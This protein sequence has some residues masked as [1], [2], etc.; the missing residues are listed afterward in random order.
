MKKYPPNAYFDS[1]LLLKNIAYLSTMN[2]IAPKVIEFLDHDN[3]PIEFETSKEKTCTCGQGIERWFYV[4]IKTA[5]HYWFAQHHRSTQ[6]EAELKSELEQAKAEIR[7]LKQKRFGKS[8]ESKK[9]NEKG[10]EAEN[11][12]RNRGQQPGSLG[13][14]RKKQ[15]LEEIE[16]I[17]EFPKDTMYCPCCRIPYEALS[18]TEDSEI[19]EIAVKGYKRKIRRR[20]Y[21]SRCFCKGTPKLLL[22]PSVPRLIPKGKIGTTIWASILMDKYGGY[23]PTHR[24]I[25]KLETYGIELAFGTV[26]DGLKKLT[27]LF[28]P[29]VKAILEKNQKEKH[30]HADETRWEVF[31][32]VEGKVSSRWY[33]W[34]FKS[35]SSVYY[36]LAPSRG[37]R[38]PKD[39][40]VGADS[41]ILNCDRYV[42]YKKL[43]SNGIVILALCWAHV[44]RDFLDIEKSF[45]ELNTWTQSWVKMIGLLYKLN[46]ERL[47][48]TNQGTFKISHEK[49]NVALLEMEIKMNDELKAEKCHLAVRKVLKSL[50]NHW[51][52][53]TIFLEHPEIPMDNNEAERRLRGPVTGRKNYYG[54][55]S[56]WSAE[57]AAAMFT[58][59]QTV[60]LWKLNPLTWLYNYLE[61][62][63]HNNSQAPID[64]APYLPWLMNDAQRELMAKSPCIF[65]GLDSS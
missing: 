50:S 12:H 34:V 51:R 56:I 32:E 3:V 25:E 30:W 36:K 63:L 18:T 26:T 58:I 65:P 9:V 49:L 33:L 45:P 42:V 19:I 21:R 28:E 2:A 16:E 27:P 47:E 46:G 31:E 38:V 60:K 24:Y 52:G 22:A 44:R 41:G 61:S 59:I 37:Y 62:C 4:Q 10:T 55:G 1:R 57:L 5:A 64:L 35:S 11:N 17:I 14:G 39:F 15:T 23:T 8:S 53:L 6:R 54:S 13:H 43:E 20:K 40:F 48:A 29:V 7:L